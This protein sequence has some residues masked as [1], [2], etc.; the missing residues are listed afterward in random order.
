MYI[1]ILSQGIPSDKYIGHG[2][3][4]FDQAKALAQAGCKVVFAVVDIRSLRRWRKWGVER[5]DREGVHVVRVN[6]PGG[7]LPRGVQN[8]LSKFA[9][10]ILY[11]IIIKEF[12]NPN[13]IHAHFTSLGYAAAHL[14]KKPAV[15]LVVTEH[16]S[17][18]LKIPLNEKL[19]SMAE[20]AY[21]TADGVIAVSPAL[22]DVIKNYFDVEAEYIP[23][24]VDTNLF[25]YSS[26]RTGAG[27]RL[28]SVGNLIERK[29]MALTIEAF[30]EA[31]K[32]VAEASLCIFGEGP[33]RGKLE[34]MIR[35]LGQEGKITLMGAR[36]RQAIAE[37][38]KR[39][40]CF[41]LPSHHETFGV[42]YI[43]A[44]A[45]GLPVIATRCG[46]PE[47][48]IH[49]G[50]GLLITVDDRHALVRAMICMFNNARDYDGGQISE[51]AK[52]LFSPEAVVRQLKVVYSRAIGR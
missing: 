26:E 38:M 48:F 31:F 44:L 14:K 23:N 34:G 36:P 11:P 1:A 32:G 33:E 35:K 25:S 49:E 21:K 2:I 47:H 42:A 51:E 18:M 39:C 30:A 27:F 13:V 22:A 40:D 20:K 9:L 19:R 28:I 16:S 29:R 7:R 4:E 45:S 12:G 50:N 6:I 52:S 41:V 37:E 5:Y 8:A 43:E 17:E 24:V 46:G 10:R 15:P 3:F